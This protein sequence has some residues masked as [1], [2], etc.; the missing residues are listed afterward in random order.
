MVPTIRKNQKMKKKSSLAFFVIFI[1]LRPFLFQR[2]QKGRPRSRDPSILR[3]INTWYGEQICI[4]S[5]S[6]RSEYY[7]FTTVRVIFFGA[8]CGA[9]F[10]QSVVPFAEPLDFI[11]IS[12]CHFSVPYHCFFLSFNV[13]L[14]HRLPLF[15]Y[16]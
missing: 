10:D 12:L 16:Y 4:L 15:F 1:R 14:L 11:N 13:N 2:S 7:F 5:R 8:Y 6:G 3:T 9:F